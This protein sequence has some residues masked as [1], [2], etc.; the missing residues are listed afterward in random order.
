MIAL[1]CVQAIEACGR[2][3]QSNNSSSR[4]TDGPTSI[5]VDRAMRRM[6]RVRCDWRGPCE[7]RAA[8]ELGGIVGLIA[9]DSGAAECL[10]AAG[11]AGCDAA[12]DRASDGRG[13]RAARAGVERLRYG[14]AHDYFR[15][16]SASC[17]EGD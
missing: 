1:P 2:G 3:P 4:G 9:A 8:R 13:Q 6:D 11:A 16:R 17:L 12:A 5:A 14:A 15:S 7:S 10:A